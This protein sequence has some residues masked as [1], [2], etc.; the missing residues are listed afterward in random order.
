M[1]RSSKRA[2]FFT[3]CVAAALLFAALSVWQFERRLW[4]LDLIARVDARIHAAPVPV[5]E[6]WDAFDAVDAEYRRVWA[7][8]VFE[9]DKAVLVDALTERGA[10]AWVMT[11]LMTANGIVFVNRG[12]V[13]PARERDYDRPAGMVTVT[14]LLR[15][16]EPGGRFLRPNRPDAGLWYSRDVAAMARARHLGRIAPFFIDAEARAGAAYP[17]GGLTVVSFRNVH[18]IYALTWLALAGLAGFG[19]WRVLR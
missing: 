5:P 16:P 17:V 19:A 3:A 10:G 14:G 18:L 15:L 13:P 7:R 11:P 4:K 12:F 6:R 8:G 9:H 1:T 2:W